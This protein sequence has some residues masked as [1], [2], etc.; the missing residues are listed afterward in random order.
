MNMSHDNNL[1]NKVIQDGEIEKSTYFNLSTV[2]SSTLYLVS[3]R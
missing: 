1:L 2:V 3:S